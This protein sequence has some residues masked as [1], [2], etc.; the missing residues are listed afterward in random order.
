MGDWIELNLNDLIDVSAP[1]CYGVL[2]PGKYDENGVQLIRIV[3]L[4]NGK[5]Q[6]KELF[7]ITNELDNE[8]S[9][10]RVKENDVLISIQGTI[11]RVAVVPKSLDGANI[12]RTIARIRLADKLFPYYLRY[13]LE[14]EVGQKLLIDAISGTTRDSLNISSIRKFSIYAPK[15][16]TEQTTIATILTT[17]DQA[18][19]KTEQLIAK[20]E[21]IK[22]GLMQ[23]LLTRGI[24]EEGNIRSE[25]T[26]EF[27]DSELGR[28]PVEWEVEEL[29]KLVEPNSPIVYGI[30]MPGYGYEKGVPV[31]KVKDIINDKIKEEGLLLTSPEIAAAYERSKLETGDLLFTIRGT[32]GRCAFVPKSLHGANITQDT[33][34]LRIKVI[35]PKFVRLY[36]AM[37]HP[38]A[39]IELNTIG[40]AVKGIN[41]RELRKLLIARPSKKESDRIVNKLNAVES[42]IE[43]ERNGLKKF[44]SQKTALMQDLLTGTVSVDS[45]IELMAN[46]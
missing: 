45:L 43:N 37:P 10:S 25:E 29:G 13:F 33:A 32:V 4:Q 15:D 1:I 5:I 41:L 2:K 9:R 22:T 35:N 39:Y 3:D 46:P 38:K 17:I 21:R 16:I 7:Q 31:I 8:F 18:I 11:G 14:S 36:F 40:L 44:L 19:E 26:H 28:I 27:K 23:D 42:V 20:Y 30:L 12:S 34:R 24:D 6:S